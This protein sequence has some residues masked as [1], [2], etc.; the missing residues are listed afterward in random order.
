MAVDSGRPIAE[1][2]RELGVNSGTL[3]NWVAAY[4]KKKPVHD[5]PSNV[6]ERTRLREQER[7][8]RELRMQV[9]FLKKATAFFANQND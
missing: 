5:E 1:M 3:T 4:R 8:L 7:E 6:S 9:S 2:A